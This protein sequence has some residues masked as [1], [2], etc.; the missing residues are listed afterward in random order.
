MFVVWCKFELVKGVFEFGVIGMFDG[1]KYMVIG[2]MC[3]C[4]LGDD[5][6]WDEYLLLN[7]KCGFLWFV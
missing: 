4:V 6:M 1:V 7:L 2:M 5:E 3:C